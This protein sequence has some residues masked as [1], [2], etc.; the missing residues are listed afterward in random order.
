MWSKTSAYD[1]TNIK[2]LEY[3]GRFVY[4]QKLF[5]VKVYA[6][7]YKR[8]NNTY[9]SIFVCEAENFVRYEKE[10]TRTVQNVSFPKKEST[11]ED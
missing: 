6:V 8:S 4:D 1:S 10:Y 5:L 2:A 7:N 11:E 9:Y 3:E